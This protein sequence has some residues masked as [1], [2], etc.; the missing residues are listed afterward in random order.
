M[1]D[2]YYAAAKRYLIASGWKPGVGGFWSC[3]F[4]Y[5]IDEAIALHKEAA[6]RTARAF[7]KDPE[8]IP[9]WLREERRKEGTHD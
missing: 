5:G 7:E 6:E 1:T 2:E 8:L 3:P 4:G 9:R